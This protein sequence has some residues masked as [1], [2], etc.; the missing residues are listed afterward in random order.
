MQDITHVTQWAC[1][2]F[3]IFVS[4]SGPLNPLLQWK[5]PLFWNIAFILEVIAFNSVK[6]TRIVG[7]CCIVYKTES[8]G[9][10]RNITHQVISL[11]Y[12]DSVIQ[13]KVSQIKQILFLNSHLQSVL[14]SIWSYPFSIVS[15]SFTKA[16][17]NDN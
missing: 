10:D 13:Q 16:Q 15:Q 1:P 2:T 7:Q 5:K 3:E 12:Y 14:A 8:T 4:V 9:T 11:G 6:P 17:W